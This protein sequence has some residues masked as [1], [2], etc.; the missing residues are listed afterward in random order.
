MY[1]RCAPL[2]RGCCP[3]APHLTDIQQIALMKRVLL[4]PRH[5]VFLPGKEAFST[6][7]GA[8]TAQ[9]GGSLD[10]CLTQVSLHMGGA[11]D[12]GSNGDGEAIP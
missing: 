4:P 11:L 10:S 2:T 9:P 1:P 5:P 12:E 8:A 6:V 7:H 3:L